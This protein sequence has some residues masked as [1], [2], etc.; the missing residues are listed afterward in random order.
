MDIDR[1][2]TKNGWSYRE[3]KTRR[4]IGKVKAVKGKKNAFFWKTYRDFQGDSFEAVDR[5]LKHNI[6]QRA[7]ELDYG[8]VNFSDEALET[9]PQPKTDTAPRI[10]EYE[11]KPITFLNLDGN[12]MVNATEMAKS[13]GK[14]P[15]DWLKTQ[16]TKDFIQA[17]SGRR[18]ILPSDLVKVINGDGG[19]TW[20]HEDLALEFARWLSPMFAIW[21]ND[22]IKQLLV[23]GVTTLRQDKES[24]TR[25]IETLQ[26]RLE[27]SQ[28][29]I[30]GKEEVI[31]CQNEVI[32]SKNKVIESKNEQIKSLDFDCALLSVTAEGNQHKIDYYEKMLRIGKTK[33]ATEIANELGTDAVTL[34]LLLSDAGIIYKRNGQWHLNPPFCDMELASERTM[35]SKNEFNFG[36]LITYTVW[37]QKGRRFI[38]A[39]DENG[40]DV[41]KTMKY[42]FW[43]CPFDNL[44]PSKAHF[45]S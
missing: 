33:T 18:K 28:K 23:S 8:Q 7:R 41:V 44:K 11:G 27:D 2:K 20:M 4:L 19:G 3:R 13:F 25:A 21:C 10:F 38:H 31:K 22:H 24:L 29:V 1:V 43:Y 6:R 45:A 26:N 36:E 35:T 42:L 40:F 14:Q 9:A 12:L 15:K 34:N 30:E 5:Q 37:T 16:S 39:L 32:E 17:L